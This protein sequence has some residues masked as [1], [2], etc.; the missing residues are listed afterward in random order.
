M[1]IAEDVRELVGHTPLIQL[2]RIRHLN[3]VAVWLVKREYYPGA[4][5][6]AAIRVARR[7]KDT[8]KLIVMVQPSFGERYLSRPLF[9]DLEQ[10]QPPALV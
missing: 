3:T 1:Q 4:A 9:R 2:N 7:L 10:L 8:G 5:L 6:G